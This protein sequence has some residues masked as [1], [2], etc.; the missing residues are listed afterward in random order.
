MN[1]VG[2]AGVHPRC[3]GTA[4]W[5]DDEDRRERPQRRVEQ[6]IFRV[7]VAAHE[8]DPLAAAAMRAAD[9]VVLTGPTTA[10]RSVCGVSRSWSGDHHA[11][12]LVCTTC[13][14]TGLGE[15]ASP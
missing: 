8:V 5:A 4:R 3:S 14:R 12:I 6:R 1:G 2:D 7:E 11:A 10:S 15:V 13:D 9:L